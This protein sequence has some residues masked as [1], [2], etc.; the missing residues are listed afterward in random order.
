MNKKL[1]D[2]IQSCEACKEF[3]QR[4]CKETLMSHEVPE[5]AWE[6]I[7]CVLFSYHGKDYFVTV[8][9][10]SNFWEIGHLD[11]SKS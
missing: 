9:C 11:T 8:C 6:K 4:H 5:Q 3:E 2:W 1:K 10:K 7:G